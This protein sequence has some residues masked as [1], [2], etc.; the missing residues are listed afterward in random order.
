MERK[1]RSEKVSPLRDTTPEMR[2]EFQ[3]KILSWVADQGS[4]LDVLDP[5]TIQHLNDRAAD[6]RAADNWVPLCQVARLAGPVWLDRALKAMAALNPQE[7]DPEPESRDGNLGPAVLTRL[8]R[9]FY[10]YEQVPAMDLAEARARAAGKSEKEIEAAR[11]AAQNVSPKDDLIIPTSEILEKL[12]ADKEA[13]W[14]DW[15]KGLSAAR[16][17]RILRPYNVSP[18][19]PK[20]GEPRGYIFG[21]LRPVFERY[22][23]ID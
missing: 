18:V 2:E 21:N 22:L 15:Q 6:D 20:R 19:Q 9:I 12:N 14:A 7:G 13:P 10:D 5:S 11:K 4:Q 17:S 1:K 8:R 23:A 3:R 16:L